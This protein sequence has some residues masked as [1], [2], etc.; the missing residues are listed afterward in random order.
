[1]DGEIVICEGYMPNPETITLDDFRMPFQNFMA[2]VYCRASYQEYYVAVTQDA[3]IAPNIQDLLQ[4]LPVDRYLQ[5][6]NTANLSYI[7]SKWRHYESMAVTRGRSMQDYNMTRRVKI[8]NNVHFWIIAA[9]GLRPAKIILRSTSVLVAPG[10]LMMPKHFF[11]SETY[12]EAQI[13]MHA[14]ET[15]LQPYREISTTSQDADIVPTKE[16]QPENVAPSTSLHIHIPKSQPQSAL[17]TVRNMKLRSDIWN[18]RMRS[19]TDL[20]NLEI[21][22][23]KL[24]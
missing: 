19:E 9:D 10:L 24:L 16:I 1:M 8:P 3:D 11:P 7:C 14:M 17:L 5:A 6:K 23:T 21:V 20:P 12:A 18:V 22:P 13:R 4:P 2:W 15:L